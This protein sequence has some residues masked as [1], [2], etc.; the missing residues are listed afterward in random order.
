MCYPTNPMNM[1][2]L[3]WNVEIYYTS[4]GIESEPSLGFSL[5]KITP[6][7]YVQSNEPTIVTCFNCILNDDLSEINPQ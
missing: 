3:T 6:F 5:S 4:T 1:V 7:T 2:G